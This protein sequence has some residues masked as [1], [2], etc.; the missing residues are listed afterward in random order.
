MNV[1]LT[2]QKGLYR[3]KLRVFIYLFIERLRER[4]S[5]AGSVP[6]TELDFMTVRS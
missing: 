4:E 2:G 3:D 1:T 6:S 5:Q